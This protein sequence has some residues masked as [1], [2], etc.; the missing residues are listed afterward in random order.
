MGVIVFNAGNDDE[1]L[2]CNWWNW[3]PTVELMRPTGVLS[4]EYFD[5]L[6]DGFGEL[7]KEQCTIVV[8]YFEEHVF[9][10]MQ[11]DARFLLS[12]EK[13]LDPDDYTFHREDFTKNYSATAVWLKQFIDFMKRSEGISVS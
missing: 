11:A 5:L 7:G 6:S 1:H 2:A 4:P 12:G 10:G 13:T 9:P 8:Q 3:R